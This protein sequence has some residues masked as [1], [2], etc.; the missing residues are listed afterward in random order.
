MKFHLFVV[1]I[2]GLFFL[3]CGTDDNN[4]SPVGPDLDISYWVDEKLTVDLGE[5]VYGYARSCAIQTDGKIVVAGY[6]NSDSDYDFTVTRFYSNGQP[7]ATFG[8]SGIVTSD[9]IVAGNDCAVQSDGKIIVAVDGGADGK[10][11]A[12]IRL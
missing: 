5:D 8:T 1:L 11:W 10:G 12:L 6:S 3:S 7:D 9:E 2:L 4:K